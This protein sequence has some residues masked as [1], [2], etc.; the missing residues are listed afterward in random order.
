MSIKVS[1]SI[2]RPHPV[3]MKLS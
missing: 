2:C 3:N 1:Y